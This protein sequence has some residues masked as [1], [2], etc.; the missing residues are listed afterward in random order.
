MKVI[1]LTHPSAKEHSIAGGKGANLG[2]LVAAGFQVPSGFVITTAAYRSFIEDS[3]L[4]GQIEQLVA[5]VN[6]DNIAELEAQ[7]F[8]IRKLFEATRFPGSLGDEIVKAYAAMGERTFV[9]V[10]SSGTAE[11]LVGASF[12]GLHDTYLDV[13]GG[14]EVLDAVKRCWASLWTARATIYRRNYGFAHMEALLAVVVQQMVPSDA[15]GVMFT[16]NPL[17]AATDE[18]VINSSWGLGEA[19]VQGIVSPDQYTVAH[20]D[21]AVIEKSLGSKM[22]QI[23]RDLDAGRNVVE[24]PVPEARRGAWSLTEPQV[25][26]LGQL[27]RRVQAYYDEMPQDIEWGIAGGT[28]YLLQSRPI[29]GV[30]FSWDAECSDWQEEIEDPHAKWTRVPMDD[31]WTGAIT[32]LMYSWRG[33]AWAYDARGGSVAIMNLQSIKRI[34]A[35]KYF[36]GE[37]YENVEVDR[38]WVKASMPAVRGF[39][40][41]RIPEDMR[42][43]AIKASFSWFDYVKMY[44]RAWVLYP[45]VGTPYGWMKKLQDYFDNRVAEARGLADDQL[46]LLSDQELER[47]LR[48][49]N[50][51]ESQYNYDVVWPG[52]F[53]YARDIMTALG[54]I[55][56]HW[57]AGDNPHAF[58]ELIAGSEKIT[59]TV[60]EHLKLHEM[61]KL[62]RASSRLSR[63][64]D[65]LRNKDFFDSLPVSEEGRELDKLVQAFLVFSGHRGHADRDIYFPRYADAPDVLYRALQAHVKSDA[66]PMILQNSNNERRERVRAEVEASIRRKPFGFIKTELFKWCLEYTLRFQ[67]YRDDERY[68]IDGNTYSIRK[69]FLEANRRL[70]ER[71]LVETERDF[72]FLTFKELWELLGN[73]DNRKLTR[74]KIRGRMKNFDD[75]D[76]KQYQP[77]KFLYRN[78]ELAENLDTVSSIDGDMLLRGIPTSRGKV[79]GVARIVKQLSQI[80]QVNK[81]EILVANSTD[82]GWTPVFAL[83]HG[84]IVET[85]GLLSHSSCLA[86][87]Y[88][89]PAAQVEGALRLIPDGATITLNGDTGEVRVHNNPPDAEPDESSG[90]EPLHAAA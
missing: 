3:G 45:E 1:D 11:D 33:E 65:R 57:Y 28:L 31:I 84:V 22:V 89:F 27:G 47:Y 51:F 39:M 50:A 12:A 62:V 59:R 60:E 26:A 9:A 2:Q 41:Q 29:T 55:V 10:R 46:P 74:A 80:D 66:D 48:Q 90:P 77:P 86:R 42:E 24:Q 53:L 35:M 6:Y 79:T 88:G 78:R 75:F 44:L 72:Y 37:A 56:Q 38:A 14:D 87:E 58:T 69:G 73:K 8:R 76:Q 5:G 20:K 23:V 15:S 40:A 83:I 54:L 52:L 30:D 85:G 49:Q 67:E 70:M 36:R 43:E 25:T 71:G 63:D 19:V 82:P 64:F 81:G 13:L 17:T 7:T 32:P 4:F 18:M 16:G 61:G 34:R 21:L 68:F